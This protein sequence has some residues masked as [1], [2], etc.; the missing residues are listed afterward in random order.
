MAEHQRVVWDKGGERVIHR[1]EDLTPDKRPQDPRRNG[2]GLHYKPSEHGVTLPD[3]FPLVVIVSDAKE[4]RLV[5][6][7]DPEP[8]EPEHRPQDDDQKGTNLKFQ[9][10]KYGGEVKDD[11][12]QEIHVKD[13]KGRMCVYKPITEDGRVVDSKGYTLEGLSMTSKKK[14]VKAG[15]R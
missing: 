5:Y 11:M 7:A 13:R 9:P 14:V 12:P 10:A 15:S 8:L 2:K 4:R 3:S 6:Q 1:Y